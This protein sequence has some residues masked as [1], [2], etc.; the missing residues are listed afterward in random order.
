MIASL[1]SQPFLWMLAF[2]FGAA[3]A[4]FACLAAERLPHQLKW[5]EQATPGLT[6]WAPPS[7]CNTCQTRIPWLFLTPILGWLFARGH[8]RT[9]CARVPI[10]Y[11]LCELTLGVICAS[12]A[13][14]FGPSWATVSSVGL[15]VTLFFLALID[16]RETWLPQVVTLPLFWA[17]LLLALPSPQMRIWGA[18]I[19]FAIIFAAMVMISLKYKENLL[20]GGDI[21]LATAAGAWVGW[22]MVLWFLLTASSLFVLG[23]MCL[24]RSAMPAG[25]ALA[26]GFFITYVYMLVGLQ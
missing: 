8:C 6:I 22:P 15:C 26:I 4:S 24:R 9:C 23:A 3:M 11:P 20:A 25:P 12:L 21:M 14:Y 17:G 2:G 5:V 13:L 1:L 10:F 19:G 18:F 16:W 7:F